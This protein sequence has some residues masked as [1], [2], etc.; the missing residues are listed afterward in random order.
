TDYFGSPAYLSQ[1]GQLYLEAFVPFLDKVCCIGPSF[2][3][4]P[5]VDDRHLTEFSLLEIELQCDL[6]QLREEIEK[7]MVAIT[8]EAV[9][10]AGPELDYLGVDANSL[11]EQVKTPF[12]TMT[13]DDA[14]KLLYPEFGVK[15]G[16]DLKSRHEHY[17]VQHVG[18]RPLFVTHFPQQI[19]FF[20]MRVNRDD[21]RIVNSMD[22][23]LPYGGEA[24]GSAEREED[25]GR[26]EKRLASSYMLDQIIRRKAAKGEWS[27][28]TEREMKEE[29]VELFRWYIDFVREHPVMHAGCG[30][31][32]TR[33]MQFLL[34]ANDIRAATTYP[35]NRE[36][37]M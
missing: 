9:G 8:E 30:I 5:S 33:V 21:E 20:N 6:P 26:L 10:R 3:A 1:T 18:N 15:W 23:L 13:Y 22:L 4:E 7:I 32:G 36:L 27:G 29:A 24:V 28:L 2:R 35:L 17:L 25:H 11:R 16:D 14:I 12:A 19:K 37:I 34:E 31:G